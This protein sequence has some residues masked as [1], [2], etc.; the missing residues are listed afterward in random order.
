MSH[1]PRSSDET[2][3]AAME[4]LSREIQSGDGVANSAIREAGQRIA[5]LRKQRDMLLGN[6]QNVTRILDAF[7]YITTLGKS[8]F[9]RLEK[10]KQAIKDCGDVL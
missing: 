8:Q 5:E 3:S 6:L 1:T 9:E 7:G 4:I 2:L 10:A